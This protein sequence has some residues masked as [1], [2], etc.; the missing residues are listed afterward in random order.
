MDMRFTILSSASHAGNMV[1]ARRVRQ[2][3]SRAG[4]RRCYCNES[5]SNTVKTQLQVEVAISKLIQVL[6]KNESYE[7]TQ[8]RFGRAVACFQQAVTFRAGQNRFRIE[9]YDSSRVFEHLSLT[10]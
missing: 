2:I 7:H 1:A 5:R 6:V 8:S 9:Y 4:S 3:V 10:S